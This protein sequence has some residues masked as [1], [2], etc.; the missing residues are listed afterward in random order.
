MISTP[1]TR[2]CSDW[3]AGRIYATV[4]LVVMWL[5]ATR[6]CVMFDGKETLGEAL[7]VKIA[8]IPAALLVAVQHTA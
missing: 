5:N 1:R 7:L 4:M 2:G 3:N 8:M 6:I